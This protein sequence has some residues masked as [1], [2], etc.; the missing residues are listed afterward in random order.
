MHLDY[1]W[2]GVSAAGIIFQRLNEVLASLPTWV[3]RAMLGWVGRRL[4]WLWGSWVRRLWV[5]NMPA[6]W[7]ADRAAEMK[8]NLHLQSDTLNI[9]LS[10]I[11]HQNQALQVFCSPCGCGGCEMMNWADCSGVAI[12]WPG[13]TRTNWGRPKFCCCSCCQIR[14][15]SQIIST[16][17][18]RNWF[19]YIHS[20]WQQDK[21]HRCN[22]NTLTS[23]NQSQLTTSL[24]QTMYYNTVFS[25][26]HSNEC[27]IENKLRNTTFPNLWWSCVKLFTEQLLCV[28]DLK[29]FH[30]Y[31]DVN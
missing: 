26:S 15:S 2:G 7:K 20:Y 21:Q 18:W 13:W 29:Q 17:M 23:H 22:F 28:S 3:A 19:S 24:C 1:R 30:I 25:W 8:R 31:P 14:I 27:G 4:A 5:C 9:S 16:V 11:L 10:L 6:E 12:G